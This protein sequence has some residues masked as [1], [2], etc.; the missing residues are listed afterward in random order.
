MAAREDQHVAIDA[1][2]ARN[3]AVRAQADLLGRFAVWTAIVKNH[4]AGLARQDPISFLTFEIAIVPF[5][6]VRIQFCNAP[7]ARKLA[8]AGGT[9]EWARKYFGE[10]YRFQPM[11]KLLSLL[12]AH[13]SQGEIS[14][15]R[16]LT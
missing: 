10:L 14:Q 5:D 15:A 12:F 11:T 3:D 7:V 9:L 1:T 2:G 4:P 8:S 6:Q 16:V 13:S